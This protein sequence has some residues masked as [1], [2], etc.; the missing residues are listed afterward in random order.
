MTLQ[1]DQSSTDSSKA[2]CGAR[3][4]GHQ[5]RG[6]EQLAGQHGNVKIVGGS[7][8]DAKIGYGMCLRAVGGRTD[9]QTSRRHQARGR[10]ALQREAAGTHGGGSS[11][12]QTAISY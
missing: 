12:A 4:R 11:P 3:Q 7:Q 2:L 1:L 6:A 8:K 10:P 9:R 5:D